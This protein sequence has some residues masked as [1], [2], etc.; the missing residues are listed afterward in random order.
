[1]SSGTESKKK[2]KASEVEVLSWQQKKELI[3]KEEDSMEREVEELISWARKLE[4]C[5]DRE[6]CSGQK[7]EKECK[8]RVFSLFLSRTN[9]FNLEVS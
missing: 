3:D 4:K 5:E 2:K 7:G 8:N 6:G 9:G 1:M